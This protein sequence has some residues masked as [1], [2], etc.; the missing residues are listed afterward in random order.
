MLAVV[1][2][3]GVLSVLGQQQI[4]TSFA[5]NQPARQPNEANMN[6]IQDKQAR[7]YKYIVVAM[8]PA[9]TKTQQ[10]SFLLNKFGRRHRR[11]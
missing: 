4:A 7:L 10:F 3:L 5:A 11:H 2:V 1:A 8:S 6:L 9:K